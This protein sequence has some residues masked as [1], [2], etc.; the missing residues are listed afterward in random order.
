MMKTWMSRPFQPY[1]SFPI[2]NNKVNFYSRKLS[3]ID[4]NAKQVTT[5]S[6][7]CC[8]KCKHFQL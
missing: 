1:A 6:Q 5:K 2:E 4:T 3:S 8:Q 7:K